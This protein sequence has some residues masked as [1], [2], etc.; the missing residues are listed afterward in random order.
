MTIA[1]FSI[2]SLVV[3]RPCHGY[4]IERIIR[5]RGMRDWTEIGF[6]SIYYLLQRLETKKYVQSRMQ[7]KATGGAERRIYR[8]TAAGRKTWHAEVIKAL[9]K[10]R[11]AYVPFL[12]GL[13]NLAHLS[14]NEKLQSLMLYSNKLNE[15]R[16]LVRENRRKAKKRGQ[17]PWHADLMFDYSLKMTE[18]ELEWINRLVSSISKDNKGGGND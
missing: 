14:R 15:R 5:Q 1:E 16:I 17:I 6:S 12:A 9:S 8:A 18:A 2:L 4:E 11:R 10:P 7:S 3:R 13:F